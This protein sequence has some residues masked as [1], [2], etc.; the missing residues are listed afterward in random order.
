MLLCPEYMADL[1]YFQS[2]E[3]SPKSRWHYRLFVAV[4]ALSK[5][6]R[7]LRRSRSSSRS[8]STLRAL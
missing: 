2:V 4:T 6:V 8:I 5:A 7:L 1:G 3:W